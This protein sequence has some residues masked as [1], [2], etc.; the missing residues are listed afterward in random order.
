MRDWYE[1][2]GKGEGCLLVDV[3]IGFVVGF[4]GMCI[5]VEEGG[6]VVF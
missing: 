3:G 2:E 5:D 1:S 6:G 4:G